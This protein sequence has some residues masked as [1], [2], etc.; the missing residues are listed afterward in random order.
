MNNKTFEAAEYPG[1]VLTE[2]ESHC[3]EGGDTYYE[4]TGSHPDGR[5]MDADIYWNYS[6]K[7]KKYVP[8]FMNEEVIEAPPI[9]YFAEKRQVIIGCDFWVVSILDMNKN[10]VLLKL[11]MCERDADIIL[12]SINTVNLTHATV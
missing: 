11:D 8:E 9:K 6:D 4:V 1:W 10:I 3:D 2:G 7:Q 12:S 5:E